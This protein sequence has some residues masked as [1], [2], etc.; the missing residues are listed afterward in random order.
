MSPLIACSIATLQITLAELLINFEFYESKGAF[1]QP[2]LAA[3]LGPGN[4]SGEPS[5]V[6]DVKP[7]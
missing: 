6:V 7:L 3:T 5:A 1:V 2:S 4:K